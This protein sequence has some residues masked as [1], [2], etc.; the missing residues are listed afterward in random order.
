[1]GKERFCSFSVSHLETDLW[2]GIDTAHA[3]YVADIHRVALAEIQKLRSILDSYI[4]TNH[5]FQESLVPIAIENNAP[6]IAIEMA[7]ASRI[8]NVGPMATVA[9]TFAQH[10]GMLVKE[11]FK[12]NEVV[13]ENGGDIYLNVQDEIVMSVF[14]GQSPLSEK[15]GVRIPAAFGELGIC[16]SAGTVGPSLSFGKADAVM[17]ACRSTALADAYA[18][19][20][21][22]KIQ[23]PDD[24]E[25]ILEKLEN[26]KDILSAIIICQDK[27]GIRGEF[28]LEILR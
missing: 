2:I 4:S 20:I 5:N 24:I 26:E 28:E 14:A 27:M 18:T 10:I 1:M 3:S 15:V 6:S 19:G 23:T 9:G 12:L 17:I 11:R 25:P 8:A 7:N 16:T 13:V 22:N 21:A